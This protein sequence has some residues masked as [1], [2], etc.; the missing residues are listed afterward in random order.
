ME[1]VGVSLNEPSGLSTAPEQVSLESRYRQAVADECRYL[2]PEEEEGLVPL[3][4]V[5]VKLQALR[6][7]RKTLAERRPDIVS[8]RE[9]AAHTELL[10]RLSVREQEEAHPELPTRPEGEWLP[11]AV[12][13]SI[14][15]KE[16]QHLA[17]LGEPGAGKS[18]TLQFIA[19]CFAQQG[20]ALERLDL[21]EDLV[22]VWLSLQ[23]AGVRLEKEALETSLANAVARLGC[24]DPGQ[25]QRLVTSWWK[26][27]RLVVLLDGLDEVPEGIRPAVAREIRRFARAP[28]GQGCRFIVASRLA[29]YSDLG[30]PFGEY[31]LCPFAGPSEARPYVA[32]WLMALKG[33]SW[34]EADQQAH[35]L[36]AQIGNQPGLS[37]LID[38]PLLLRLVISTY[39]STGEIASNQADLHQRYVEEVAWA[40]ALR[41]ATPPA[42]RDATLEALEVIAWKLHT[43]G[44]QAAAGLAEAV[45]AEVSGVEDARGLVDFL[46]QAMGLLV[47]YGDGAEAHLAFAHLTFRQYLVARRL[48]QAWQTDPEQTWLFLKPR[49]HHPAWR[50][51]VLLLATMISRKD[52]TE[53]TERI[54][55]AASIYEQELHRDLL[56]AGECLGSGVEVN[57]ELRRLIL[58]QLLKLYLRETTSET[59]QYEPA[60][61]QYRV[62]PIESIFGSLEEKGHADI[63]TSLTAIA[64]GE[65]KTERFAP[66]RV[67]ANLALVTRT[68]VYL[69]PRFLYG[70]VKTTGVREIRQ[71]IFF[72]AYLKEAIGEAKTYRRRAAIKALGNLRLGSSE[73]IPILLAALEDAQTRGVAAEALGKVGPGTAE[74]AVA[75]VDAQ[76]QH[77]HMYGWDR[78]VE[79]IVDAL[80][81]LGQRHPEVVDLLLGIERSPEP[82]SDLPDLHYPVA[83]ALCKSAETSRHAMAFVLEGW[84]SLNEDIREGLHDGAKL[85]TSASP[86]VVRYLLDVIRDSENVRM[87]NQAGES[88]ARVVG[89]TPLV[90]CKVAKEDGTFGF[91]ALD[92]T[93][94]LFD[95]LLR[96]LSHQ[97]FGGVALSLLISW[98]LN[99]PELVVRLINVVREGDAWLLAGIIEEEWLKERQVGR[100][101]LAEETESFFKQ[102]IARLRNADGNTRD[103][104]LNGWLAAT[105]SAPKHSWLCYLD[106]AIGKTKHQILHDAYALAYGAIWAT[107]E[108]SWAKQSREHAN[109]Y[110]VA[111]LACFRGWN[112]RELPY[113]TTEELREEFVSG[114]RQALS[115]LQSPGEQAIEVLSSILGGE[116]AKLANGDLDKEPKE[117]DR[118][119]ERSKPSFQE[120]SAAAYAL[121]QL[122]GDY[123]EAQA[124]LISNLRPRFWRRGGGFSPDTEFQEHL[125]RALGYVTSAN[126]DLVAALLNIA[127]KHDEDVY[128]A[129]SEA[130]SRLKNPN[131]EAVPLLIQGYEKLSERGRSCLLKALCTVEPLTPEI[132]DLL[133]KALREKDPLVRSAA[134]AGLGNVKEPTPGVPRAVLA[135]IRHTLAAAETIGKLADRIKSTGETKV[136][137]ELANIARILCKTTR[138][139]LPLY[140]FTTGRSGYD[141]TYEALNRVVS[142]LTLLEVA[143]LPTNLPLPGE[144]GAVE[145]PQQ[146]RPSPLIVAVGV[147]VAA[148]LGLASN[149]VAAYLQERYQLI[150]DPVRFAIVL[151]VF[152]ASLVAGV[153]LALR[154]GKESDIYGHYAE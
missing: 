5:F 137:D 153:S 97:T 23:E 139:D 88:L 123:P 85:I 120:R 141:V 140:D 6:S 49:I 34:E 109:P 60:I 94:E 27:G 59:T 145:A 63:L 103:A 99:R 38:N 93:E 22:P 36:L 64:S 11:L 3:I 9:R 87:R 127:A 144:G 66:S 30:Q 119:R 152:L 69:I 113:L 62:R 105:R 136:Q 91:S 102:S 51:S 78:T 42:P 92:L 114:V 132:I 129:G 20:W 138:G 90:R 117:L 80:G 112:V 96:R 135:S 73:T 121:A 39:V 128:R 146:R 56:L 67:A 13:L 54:L 100:P 10:D 115:I 40:R 154:A 47:A 148:T 28:E 107:Q 55:K 131:S 12:P 21:D 126:R 124:L 147:L 142:Q 130:I 101:N 4:D 57:S 118:W 79:R 104:E 143:A 149:I 70:L 76:R 98:G 133:L 44:E 32:R 16:Q 95:I 18:T 116:A 2:R 43:R 37:R 8:A 29:G 110:A 84:R 71:V 35:D 52:A 14:A 45:R 53:L 1:A 86:E 19:L 33:V 125:V 81:V 83:W 41:R 151:G 7:E 75:L 150:S 82:E 65:D 72:P 111:A 134:A 122:A 46:R 77:R 17:L 24:L 50:E 106:G 68:S 25:A 61:Q 48:K 74:V 31:V 89:D 26:A 58:D 15:L 108:R